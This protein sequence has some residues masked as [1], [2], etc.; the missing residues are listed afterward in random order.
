MFENLSAGELAYLVVGG[1]M[2]AVGIA[3]MFALLVIVG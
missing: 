1:S 3:V 2:I